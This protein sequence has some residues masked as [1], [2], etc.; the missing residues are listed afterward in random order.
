[1]SDI[2]R[3]LRL[4]A[5][6]SRIKRGIKSKY[7]LDWWKC[8]LDSCATYHTFFVKEFLSNVRKGNVTMTG[9][10]NAGTTESNVTGWF[11]K[12]KVWLNEMGIAN[13]LSIPML[14]S[15]G[16]KCQPIPTRIG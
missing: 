8:Y 9:S 15:A 3:Q 5:L 10:C 14:E 7:A 6:E 4:K 16:Y 1:M 2:R 12:F 11:G 13:L